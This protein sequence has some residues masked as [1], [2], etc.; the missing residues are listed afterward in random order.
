MKIAEERKW[1]TKTESHGVKLL[2]ASGIFN[3]YEY[4]ALK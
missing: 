3:N 2:I 4:M 1:M